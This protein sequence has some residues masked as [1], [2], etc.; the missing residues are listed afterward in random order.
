MYV[1]VGATGNTG[2]VITEAL[3]AKGEK[4]RAIGRD[5]TRLKPLTDR[6]AEACIGSLDNAADMTRAFT[7]ATAVYTMIPPNYAAPNLRAYQQHIAEALGTA[8]ERAQVP[9]VVNLSSL[10][11]QH[12]EGVGPIKGLHDVEQRFN[13]LTGSHVLH[14]RP[15]Y[16]MENLLWNQGLIATQGING[17]PARGDLAL[18]MIA[19]RDI[20]AEATERLLQRDFRG[21]STKELLGQRNLT[22][23]EAT[24]IIGKAVGKPALPYVQFPYDAAEQAMLGLGM[25]ADVANT[26][27]E[28]YHALNDGLLNPTEARTRANT[29]ATSFEEFSAVFGARD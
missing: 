10:G 22:M 1:I 18:P 14:L 7:G 28:L 3:L 12:A 25:S 2:K 20:A 5:T 21:K 29:T 6:G 8:L 23:M 26:F 4:V 15:G 9:F 17:T 19:T 11:A 16:F 27:I 13:R 24:A